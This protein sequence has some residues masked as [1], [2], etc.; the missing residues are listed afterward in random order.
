MA[1]SK[2]EFTDKEL[3]EAK[4][5]LQEEAETRTLIS[6]SQ[7]LANAVGM[8]GMIGPDPTGGTVLQQKGK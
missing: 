5:R 3:A 8:G 2:S 6:R 7:R 1:N 4:A